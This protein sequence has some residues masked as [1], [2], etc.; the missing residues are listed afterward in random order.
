MGGWPG[1]KPDERGSSLIIGRRMGRGSSDQRSE[2]TEALGQ[3][4]DPR[5]G[6]GVHAEMDELLQQTVVA[7]HPQCGVTRAD[8][9]LSRLDDPTQ[10]HRQGE[11]AHDGPV[12]AEQALEALLSGALATGSR[13][14]TGVVSTRGFRHDG[15]RNV[16]G[17]PC[18]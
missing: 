12:C 9:I 7:D 6:V 15:Q 4:T 17:T 18:C 2:Y 3:V 16:A 14:I 10:H 1:G 5:N 8:Q 13:A 11:L